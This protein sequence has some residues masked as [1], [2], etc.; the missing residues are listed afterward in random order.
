MP[1]DEIVG[2][3][4]PRTVG[5]LRRRLAQMGHPWEVQLNLSDDDPLPLPSRG[6]DG[7]APITPDTFA[8]IDHLKDALRAGPVPTSPF[9]QQ[10][11]A[12]AGLIEKEA[13]HGIVGSPE[14]PTNMQ[15]VS[16][17]TPSEES[18]R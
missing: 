10:E 14:D 12:L 17:D 16:A 8:S 7:S 18:A 4:E 11:W 15:T 13:L 9:L 6:G 3:N 2:R 5:E 1:S